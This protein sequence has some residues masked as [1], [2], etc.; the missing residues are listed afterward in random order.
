[1]VRFNYGSPTT[2]LQRYLKPWPLVLMV[3]IGIHVLQISEPSVLS[4]TSPIPI[5]P[6]MKKIV[7]WFLIVSIL[8]ICLT[9]N[10]W[11]EKRTHPG[12]IY[13][14]NGF[15]FQLGS[16]HTVHKYEGAD[17]QTY[18]VSIVD[19][20]LI[21]GM[22]SLLSIYSGNH[23]KYKHTI[24]G[25]APAIKVQIN[26]LATDCVQESRVVTRDFGETSIGE[27][28]MVHFKECLLQFWPDAKFPKY[29]HVAYDLMSEEDIRQAEAILASIQLTD[30]PETE[31]RQPRK[32]VRDFL[33]ALEE[34]HFDTLERFL[35]A[36]FDLNNN[37]SGGY[38]IL[39]R[40]VEIAHKTHKVSLLQFLL[41]HGADLNPRKHNKSGRWISP[42]SR[43]ANLGYLD[44]VTFLVEQG[45][46]INYPNPY[47]S[48]PLM[49]AAGL[50]HVEMGQ[51]LIEKGADVTA[52]MVT[53]DTALHMLL[54]PRRSRW[55]NHTHLEFA[56]LLIQHGVDVLATNQHGDSALDYVFF[57]KATYD[58]FKEYAKKRLPKVIVPQTKV[59]FVDCFYDRSKKQLHAA[60]EHN[61]VRKVLALLNA[62]QDP[63]L[64]ASRWTPMF[65]AAHS[66]RLEIAKILKTAGAD[67]HHMED[68]CQHITPLFAAA[69]SG[70]TEMVQYLLEQ[71]ADPNDQNA[72]G[73]RP[74]HYASANGSLGAAAALLK[75][76]ADVNAMDVK[77]NTA[78][79]QSY[80]KLY[81]NTANKV[82]VLNLLLEHGAHP[83]LKNTEGVSVLDQFRVHQ[84]IYHLLESHGA[85]TQRSVPSL[86]F[87]RI[88]TVRPM[89][90]HSSPK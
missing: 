9:G 1:M 43:A 55:L 61:D 33:W 71:G 5:G 46:P 63:N 74:L 56:K 60:V 44:V 25:T 84:K 50:G 86:P 64:K 78:L 21:E 11:S 45:A 31:P 47:G 62:G 42:L 36:G 27:K 72:R 26:G 41:D 73:A 2:S 40:A 32:P 35:D 18:S 38:Y 14:G 8:S 48:Y 66:N 90:I 34:E 58:R 87:Q 17:F 88:A 13:V 16:K 75:N 65:Y 28:V 19:E 22:S 37:L 68:R 30:K 10:A 12:Q 76:G 80:L 51:F 53:G 70:A 69:H 52:K 39:E 54:Q 59:R 49:Q 89:G 77:G 83:S 57:Y 24:K 82:K 79:S 81:E 7:D 3:I 6:S 20:S 29:L 85:K 4:A 23:P 67:I 15:Q